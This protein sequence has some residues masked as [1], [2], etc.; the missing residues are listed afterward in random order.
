MPDIEF[1]DLLFEL[2]K[3]DFREAAVPERVTTSV[4]PKKEVKAK[5]KV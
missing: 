4:S 5:A 3:P 1:I 2:M